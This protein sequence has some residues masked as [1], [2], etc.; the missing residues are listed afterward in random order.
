[1]KYTV[2]VSFNEDQMFYF[3]LFTYIYVYRSHWDSMHRLQE[4]P[5]SDK[6]ITITDLQMQISMVVFSHLIRRIAGEF[7]SED[8]FKNVFYKI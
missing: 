6:H 2:Y 1:M 7:L 3:I 4:R 8:I 5:I